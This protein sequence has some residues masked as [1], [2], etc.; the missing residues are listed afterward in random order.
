MLCLGFKPGA[1]G[2]WEQK[3]PL[4]YGGIQKTSIVKSDFKIRVLFYLTDLKFSELSSSWNKKF[5]NTGLFLFI[6]VFSA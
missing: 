5:A 3:D 4:R 1:A 2:W 6:F